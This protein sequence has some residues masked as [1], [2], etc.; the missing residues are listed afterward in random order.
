MGYLFFGGIT[1]PTNATVLGMGR[2]SAWEYRY[3]MLFSPFLSVSAAICHISI[4]SRTYRILAIVCGRI[5]GWVT[6]ICTIS[7]RHHCW[8]LVVII[9]HHICTVFCFKSSFFLFLKIKYFRIFK[10]KL[11]SVDIAISIK[12]IENF[13]RLLYS[14]ITFEGI[15]E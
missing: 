14:L 9:W 8:R 12:W 6:A 10:L 7:V 4:V 11:K 3:G 1:K 5:C 15:L 13:R 2:G